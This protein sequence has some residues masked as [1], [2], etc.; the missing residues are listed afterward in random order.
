MGFEENLKSA[1]AAIIKN[2][3]STLAACGDVSRNVMAPPARSRIEQSIST[4]SMP[5]ISLPLTPQTG[6]YYEIWLDG[7]RQLAAKKIHM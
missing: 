6:A 7:K 4:G 1:I 2:M 3:G 5:K